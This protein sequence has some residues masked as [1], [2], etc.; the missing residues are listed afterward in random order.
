MLAN[1]PPPE[2]L[3][4]AALSRDLPQPGSTEPR[5]PPSGPLRREAPAKGFPCSSSC[6]DSS[7][8]T[9]RGQ[10]LRG[11]ARKP[12][13]PEEGCSGAAA[14]AANGRPSL[15]S[16]D[17]SCCFPAVRKGDALKASW[18]GM[19]SFPQGRKEGCGVLP[20]PPSPPAADPGGPA[21]WDTGV[22]HGGGGRG[23][24]RPHFLPSDWRFVCHKMLI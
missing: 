2:A 4:K 12:K 18:T 9:R 15:R 7:P 14:A 16:S 6:W 22:G 8:A 17:T 20:L 10:Q 5:R 1:P 3:P 19:V 23:G 13:Q 24:A 11:P 21:S